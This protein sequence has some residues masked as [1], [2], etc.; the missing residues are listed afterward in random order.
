MSQTERPGSNPK[1]NSGNVPDGLAKGILGFV[2]GAGVSFLGMHF[3]GPRE[4]I[5]I[6]QPAQEPPGEGAVL[7]MPGS[8]PG[9]NAAGPPAGGGGPGGGAGK[10]NLAALV[11]KLELL[12]RNDLRLHVDFAPGQAGKIAAEL[13]DLAAAQTLTADEAQSRL[14]ALETSL[15]PEQ[16]QIVD[17]IGMPFNRPAAGGP[18]GGMQA[19]A[20]DENPFTQETNEKRLKELLERLKPAAGGNATTEN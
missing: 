11:G 1:G 10:R 3:Y 9:A 4:Y 8:T 17:S 13:A 6:P 2:L 15:T 7:T 20:P 18:G 19:P 12:S 16:K 14:E 5:R